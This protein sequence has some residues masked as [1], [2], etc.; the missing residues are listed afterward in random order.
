MRLSSNGLKVNTVTIV[1]LSSLGKFY[2]CNLGY[3][4]A[5]KPIPYFKLATLL[6][7]GAIRQGFACWNYCGNN[8]CTS[9]N[10]IRFNCWATY[11]LWSLR[12]TYTWYHLRINWY[13]QTTICRSCCH[14]FLLVAASLATMAT[15]GSESYIGLA[16][17]LALMMGVIQLLL[18]LFKAGFL[19]NFLS[20]PIVSG[21][22]S[23]A[24]IIIGANQISNLTGIPIPGNNRIQNLIRSLFDLESGNSLVYFING[25]FRNYC[26]NPYQ[27]D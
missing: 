23:A 8:A 19:V 1:T 7:Q 5:K 24:A 12:V 17:V 13:F 22:T 15:A 14:G 27:K 3:S 25:A 26:L 18:G 20:K 16:I 9:R 2:I 6:Q 11:G 4:D 10:G 21:F